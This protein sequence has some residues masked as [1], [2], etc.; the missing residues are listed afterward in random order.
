[1]FYLLRTIIVICRKHCCNKSTYY[2][3]LETIIC[4]GV[5]ISRMIIMC[6][7]L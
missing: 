6:C 1:M 5:M 3:V 4:W 2:C 7:K